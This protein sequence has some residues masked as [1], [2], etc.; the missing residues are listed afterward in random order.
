MMWTWHEID[1]THEKG[2]IEIDRK[3]LSF[4]T[5]GERIREIEMNCKIE[6]LKFS[7]PYEFWPGLDTCERVVIEKFKNKYLQNWWI[8]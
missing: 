1:N 3:Y 4:I 6:F 8:F 5:S 7:T 2:A